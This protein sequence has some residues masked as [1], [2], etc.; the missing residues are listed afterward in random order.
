MT[1]LSKTTYKTWTA[2]WLP[3]DLWSLDQRTKKRKRNYCVQGKTKI[4]QLRFNPTQY[5]CIFYFLVSYVRRRENLQKLT[6]K[7]M[8]GSIQKLFK[9]V[10]GA[11]RIGK[12]KFLN[13]AFKI[14]LN[15]YRKTNHQCFWSIDMRIKLHG[16]QLVLASSPTD[17]YMIISWINPFT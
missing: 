5:K 11:Q 9:A 7:I 13:T 16:D 14:N 1:P 12:S 10:I 6:L 15:L 8:R 3:L 4:W 17:L 2:T